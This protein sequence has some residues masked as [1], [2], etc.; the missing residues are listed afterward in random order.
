MKPIK[1]TLAITLCTA[2][3]CTSLGTVPAYA[4]A[5][6]DSTIQEV[7]G[8]LEIITGDDSGNLK[9]ENTVTR[10]EFAKMLVNASIYKDTVSSAGNASPFKD[11]PYTHWAANYIKTAV[12]QGWL[13]GYLDG[14]YRPSN[15]VTCAEA[16]TA[17]LKLLGYTASDFSGTF[18]YAQM[19]LYQSLD[20][21]DG[22]SAAAAT[23]MTRKNCMRLFYNLLSANTKAGAGENSQ[24]YAQ[25]LG[26]ALDEDGD[27]DYDDILDSTMDG[28]LVL[29]NTLSSLLSFTPTTVY[30]NDSLSAA[31]A[32]QTYD[33]I[34]Y[35]KERKTVWAYA[36]RVTG[37]LQEVA[38]NRQNPTKVT[39]A[40][41]T[42]DVS[43]TLATSTLGTSG[44]LA[45]GTNVTLLLGKDNKVVAAY[46]ADT[47]R[48]EEIVG[49]ITGIDKNATYTAADGTTYTQPSTTILATDGQSYTV[50]AYDKN[51]TEGTCV[52]VTFGSSATTLSRL[53]TTGGIS[54]TV[55]AKANLIG[56]TP[57]AED[58][59]MLDVNDVGGVRTYLSRINGLQLDS[60]QV[61][62]YE[63]N[64][65]GVVTKLILK[66][67]TGDQYTYGLLRSTTSDDSSGSKEVTYHFL[68]GAENRTFQ[69]S[70]TN[71]GY[72]GTSGPMQIEYDSDG[73]IKS[74][75]KLEEI[76]NITAITST[77]IRNADGLHTISDEVLVYRYNNQNGASNYY[78]M[79]RNAIDS[80]K[81]TISAY[82]DKEDTQGGRVRVVIMK[83]NS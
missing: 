37:T 59:Q 62:Y 71:L 51:L 4:A 14:T 5:G 13:T 21:D 23:P 44:G 53:P 72:L 52:T 46:A 76:K 80:T 25:K 32:L 7:I 58:V 60:N 34:Y 42:Y 83:E 38:P 75:R 9:L 69:Q 36:R 6:T 64:A 27:P 24:V 67:V 41:T 73:T 26:Y 19:A 33:I 57:I 78:V 28:P 43:G 15:A 1:R 17:V 20:L 3:I 30:R 49:V 50:Q 65:V 74:L 54:G 79:D 66:D 35:S 56:T 68:I 55:N 70:G 18:P 11:V 2:T 81:Y 22:I 48:N 45:I 40:G 16:A 8:A 77:S 47:M 82:Y 29:T 10:A 39:V 12:A 31:S 63:K 61:K